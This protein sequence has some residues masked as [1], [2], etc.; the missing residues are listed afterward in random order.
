MNKGFRIEIEKGL[1]SK[2]K[3][4]AEA[5]VTKWTTETLGNDGSWVERWSRGGWKSY[6]RRGTFGYR[7]SGMKTTLEDG[8]VF[9]RISKRRR[10]FAVMRAGHL[11]NLDG[12]PVNTQQCMCPE[13]LGGTRVTV[14]VM[15]ETKKFIEHGE[16]KG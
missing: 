12:T 8:L 13:H 7:L 4:E 5:F 14:P 16:I 11:R 3:Q 6:L 9:R 1:T 10:I 2:Q 15:P